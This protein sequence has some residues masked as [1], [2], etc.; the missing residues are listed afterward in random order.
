MCII[1]YFKDCVQTEESSEERE[2]QKNQSPEGSQQESGCRRR[3]G[4]LNNLS[5][6][7]PG[8]GSG[9]LSL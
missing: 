2:S 1:A 8:V 5:V 6:S 4:S 3:R 9:S 7:G